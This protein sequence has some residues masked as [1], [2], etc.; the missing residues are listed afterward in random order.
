MLGVVA[1]LHVGDRHV[2]PARQAVEQRRR[3][4][5]RLRITCP[6]DGDG[7]GRAG[8]RRGCGPWRRRSGRARAGSAHGARSCGASTVC[9]SDSACDRLQEPQPGAEGAEQQRGDER[10]HAE[11]SGALVSRPWRPVCCAALVTAQSHAVGRSRR[12][13]RTGAHSG[14]AFHSGLRLTRM[15]HRPSGTSTG[16][17]T[18]GRATPTTPTTTIS[19]W[20]ERVL[21]AD[22]HPDDRHRRPRRPRRRAP[23][24]SAGEPPLRIDR[25]R[26]RRSRRRSRRG[27][28]RS[29]TTRAASRRE[30]VHQ[31]EHEPGERALLRAA[32]GA[33]GGGERQ[34]HL[35]RD[36]GR[37][38]VGEQRPLQGEQHDARRGSAGAAGPG[39]TT[40]ASVACRVA[41]AS[42]SELVQQHDAD[43]VAG[44]RGR[45]AAGPRASGPSADEPADHVGDGADR[46]ARA[47]PATR[48]AA[49]GERRCRR[50]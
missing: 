42:V 1:R 47:A 20:V 22:E 12:S 39:R 7:A 34:H 8:C 15:H 17:S 14:S 48:R 49:G 33:G 19:R 38:Q 4:R 25:D 3:G 16:L 31:P 6:V 13:R 11:P 43:E 45:R 35:Q 41:E 26:G 37:A 30:V 9:C 29:T 36:A 44:G 32:A 24:N 18:N 23:V 28:S 2:E 40:R 21:L 46:D 50:R 5:C 10:E 27:P